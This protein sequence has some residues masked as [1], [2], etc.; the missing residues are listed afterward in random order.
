MVSKSNE[1]E[2]EWITPGGY[3]FDVSVEQANRAETGTLV[4]HVLSSR[5]QK[6]VQRPERWNT[7]KSQGFNKTS[8]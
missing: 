7:T 6:G 8:W 2:T 4:I 5:S 1:K 3:E